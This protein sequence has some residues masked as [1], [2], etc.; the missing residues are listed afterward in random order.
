M[1]RTRLALASEKPDTCTGPPRLSSPQGAKQE[2]RMSPFIPTGYLT[3]T[4]AIDRVVELRQGGDLSRLLTEDERATLR[5]WRDYFDRI[6][7]PPSPA[8]V[9]PV[10]KADGSNYSG[11]R[12]PGEK[13]PHRL[14]EA[15][16]ERPDITR[17]VLRDLKEKEAFFNEQRPAAGEVLRHLLYTGRVPWEIITEDD[18]RIAAP[19]HLSGGNQWYEA[20][21]SNRV[22]FRPGI[23]SVTGFPVISRDALEAAFNSDGTVKDEPEPVAPEATAEELNTQQTP[24]GDI[25]NLTPKA[26]GKEKKPRAARKR[27]AAADKISEIRYKKVKAKALRTWS[28]PKTRPGYRAMADALATADKQL[29]KKHP[30]RLGFASETMRKILDGTY[31]PARDLG[32]GPL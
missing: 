30:N 31:G 28:N 2:A 19:K 27:D 1:S 5:N 20:L 8:P 4:A 32:I 29:D 16:P 17:E 24:H 11:A 7:R 21:K 3:L 26:P 15:K 22:T 18:T 23:L 12:T 13:Y 14:V 25:E 9:T 10:P 6:R